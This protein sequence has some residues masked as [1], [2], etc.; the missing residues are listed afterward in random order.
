MERTV[1]PDPANFP[2]Y[3]RRMA[4]YLELYRR[5]ADLMHQISQEQRSTS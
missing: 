2:V 5:N 4:T 1:T 3:E